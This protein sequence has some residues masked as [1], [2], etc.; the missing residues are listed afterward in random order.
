MS[1]CVTDEEGEICSRGEE[2]R[3]IKRESVWMK[4]LIVAIDLMA[5]IKLE[6]V[7]NWKSEEEERWKN[8][9]KGDND[10]GEEVSG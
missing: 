1:G 10:T 2:R 5:A 9:E 4:D 3:V 7:K 6:K 8:G